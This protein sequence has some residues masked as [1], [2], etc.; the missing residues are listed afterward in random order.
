[1][2]RLKVP[3]VQTLQAAANRNPNLGSDYNNSYDQYLGKAWSLPMHQQ[4]YKS[5]E[6]QAQTTYEIL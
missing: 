4:R 6:V 3:Y 1:M 2:A 5:A